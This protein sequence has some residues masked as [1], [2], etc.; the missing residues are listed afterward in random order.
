MVQV[1]LYF[2]M[3]NINQKERS[4]RFSFIDLLNKNDTKYSYNNPHNYVLNHKFCKKKDNPKGYTPA[5]GLPV[6]MKKI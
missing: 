3:I 6:P 4:W 2:V 1:I 5:D